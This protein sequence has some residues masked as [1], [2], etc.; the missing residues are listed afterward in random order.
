MG[1]SFALTCQ[2]GDGDRNLFLLPNPRKIFLLPNPR[3]LFL[4]PNHA[5]PAMAR[6]FI[7]LALI[8][9]FAATVSGDVSSLDGA[10]KQELGMIKRLLKNRA[11]A[12]AVPVKKR[13]FRWNCS[14]Q[15]EE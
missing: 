9:V 7:L 14:E 2:S 15:H 3:N 10:T 5:C 11:V 13:N 1:V 4:L 6:Y 12:T 8:L